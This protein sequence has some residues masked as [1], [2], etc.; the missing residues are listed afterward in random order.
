MDMAFDAN[1]EQVKES[2]CDD[3]TAESLFRKMLR[4]F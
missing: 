1:N 2:S 4:K 3:K